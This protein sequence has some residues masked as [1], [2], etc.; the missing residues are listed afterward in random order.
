[1][2]LALSFGVLAA[3]VAHAQ[4][5]APSQFCTVLTPEEVSTALGVEVTIGDSTE[6][7]CTYQ[8]DFATGTFA[9]LNAR[10]ED[11]FDIDI[12]KTVFTDA[13]ETTVAG[14]PALQT[15]DASLLY[16]GLPAGGSFT[17][18]LVGSAAD[19]VD[20]PAAMVGLAESAIPRLSNIALPTLE[21]M[22]SIPTFHQDPELEAQFPATVGGQPI[23]VQSVAGEMVV[24][25][26]GSDPEDLQQLN[27]F[28]ASIGKST[29][30]V[31][32]GFA[33]WPG[34]P[35][36]SITAV[37]IRGTDMAS[38]APQII[39]LFMSN[40]TSPQQTPVQVAGKDVTKLNEAGAPDEQALHVYPRNDVLWTVSTVEPAL[41]EVFGAL[42]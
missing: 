1:L 40:M 38:V 24:S 10:Y 8:S 13:T 19:G 42:P 15:A 37:R 9:S 33:F 18:Q 12:M 28:L 7:D 4:S 6:I 41:T 16:T 20:V 31:S 29:N 22:P 11:S 5:P 14:L 26:L 23:D 32:V 17:L 30:D 25:I 3:P 36:G 27:D 34:P 35:A 39:P 21:P 2:A